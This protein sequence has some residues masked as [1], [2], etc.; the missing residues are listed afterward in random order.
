MARLEVAACLDPRA[1]ALHLS[2]AQPLEADLWVNGEEHDGV[3]VRDERV[4]PAHQGAR[5]HGSYR[6]RRYTATGKNL[7]NSEATARDAYWMQAALALAPCDEDYEKGNK[8]P[9]WGLVDQNDSVGTGVSASSTSEA[10]TSAA[11]TS[12]VTDSSDTAG[13]SS[14]VISSEA[15]GSAL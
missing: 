6:P 15:L 7:M 1:V 12:W 13:V 5:Y 9:L 2:R 11:V 10:A 4:A 14:P 8:A 3:E